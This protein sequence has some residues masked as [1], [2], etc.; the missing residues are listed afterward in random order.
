MGLKGEG[1]GEEGE[2]GGEGGTAGSSARTG[3]V[4]RNNCCVL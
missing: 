1:W 2:G 4:L 3:D